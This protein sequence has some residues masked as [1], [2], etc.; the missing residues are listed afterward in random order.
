MGNITKLMEI[1]RFTGDKFDFNHYVSIASFKV[2]KI[3]C[4][5]L[6]VVL[7]NYAIK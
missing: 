3:F 5:Y 2:C 7:A 4:F 1:I 6:Y